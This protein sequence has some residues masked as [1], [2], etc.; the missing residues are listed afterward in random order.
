M[1]GGETRPQPAQAAALKGTD[2]QTPLRVLLLAAAL[3]AAASVHAAQLVTAVIPLGYHT[4]DEILPV[5]RPLVPPPGSV[6]GLSNQLVIRTTP[7]NL[8]AVRQVL[9]RLDRAPRDL[10]ITVRRGLA[11]DIQ[12]AGVAGAAA[13][14]GRDLHGSVGSPRNKRRAALSGGM[15]V[16]S[17]RELREE[18]G[19]QRIRVLEGHEAF[20]QTGK[21]LPYVVHHE[22]VAGGA[23]QVQD[24]VQLQNA[25]TG[26]YVRPRLA[27]GRVFLDILPESAR[28][29]S[30][31]GGLD[32]QSA[33]T[34]VSGRLG[35][36]I[37]IA[38]FGETAGRHTNAT[39]YSTA[40]ADTAT[41][42]IFVK[43]QT[44]GR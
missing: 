41:Q 36:W 22:T 34:T 8:A 43:V 11:D 2:L 10:I 42:S 9:A 16:Y 19:V 3:L 7:A 33:R 38:G 18:Q 13:T 12:G 28:H 39:I 27:G 40:D 26:F 23:T 4:L 21:L 29:D 15:R 32:V 24:S 31:T 5:V 44:A 37:E 17:T 20:I 25:T 1:A 6:S 14:S 35:Q 30:A